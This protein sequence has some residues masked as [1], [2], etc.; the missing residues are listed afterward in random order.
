MK[1]D[2]I[3]KTQTGEIWEMKHLGI[4]TGTTETRFTNK[5]RRCMNHDIKNCA[6]NHCLEI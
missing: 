1:I 6:N 3:K 5:H 2:I 4:R